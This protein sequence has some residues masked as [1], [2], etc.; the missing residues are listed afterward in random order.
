MAASIT[1]LVVRYFSAAMDTGLFSTLASAG[2]AVDESPLLMACTIFTIETPGT[3]KLGIMAR[4]RG[5]DWLDADIYSVSQQGFDVVVSLLEDPEV[6]ELELAEEARIC[7]KLGLQFVRLPI[8]DLGAP[9]LSGEVLAILSSLNQA[10]RDGKAIVIHCRMAYGRAPMIAA[11]L[12]ILRGRNLNDAVRLL[13][14]VRG[15]PVPETDA[16]R[17]WLLDFENSMKASQKTS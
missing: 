5:G 14:A 10:W 1:R 3:A 12:M 9:P 7:A 16:Q 8:Q 17:A 15:T 11:S 6:E 2:G 13:S 4:P